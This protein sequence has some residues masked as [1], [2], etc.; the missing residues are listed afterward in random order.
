MVTALTKQEIL[1]QSKDHQT[2]IQSKE[3]LRIR[4]DGRKSAPLTFSS[5]RVQG[6]PLYGC[7]TWWEEK[8]EE[9]IESTN[10][11]K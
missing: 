5:V 6:S 2:N 9:N 1:S 7:P 11:K 3:A 10:S 8:V 4:I